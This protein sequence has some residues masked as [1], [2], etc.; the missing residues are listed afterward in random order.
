MIIVESL[1]NIN[2]FFNRVF[3]SYYAL[4]LLFLIFIIFTL[5]AITI[6]SVR[7]YLNL[8]AFYLGL[9][10]LYILLR[11]A[12]SKL[13]LDTFLIYMSINFLLIVGARPVL[14][15]PIFKLKQLVIITNQKIRNID[16]KRIK[17]RRYQNL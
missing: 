11:H 8:P 6:G 12:T 16:K 10:C 15:M 9:W 1:L 13:D 7:L 14:N 4:C 2:W 17:Y 5:I 3:D